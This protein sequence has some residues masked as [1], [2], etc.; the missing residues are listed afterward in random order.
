MA[1]A[2]QS[3]SEVGG[4]RHR[5]GLIDWLAAE[6]EQACGGLPS[7]PGSSSAWLANGDGFHPIIDS[8]AHLN[9]EMID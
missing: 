3:W 8:D 4:Q 6:I 2:E 9:A 7:V 5:R 1:I